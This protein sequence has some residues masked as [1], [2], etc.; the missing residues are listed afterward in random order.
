MRDDGAA[1]PTPTHGAAP[2][3][4]TLLPL[5][6]LLLLGTLWGLNFSFSKIGRLGGVHPFA[7]VTWQTLGAGTVLLLVC[8]WRRRPP[9]IRRRHLV[10]YVGMGLLGIVLPNA[11]LVNALAYVPAGLMAILVTTVPL[12]TYAGALP[13][14][15]ERFDA[16]RASGILF[17][18]AGAL[19]ILLPRASLPDPAMQGWVLVGLLTPTLYA[20]S[21]L[22][23]ARWRPLDANAISLACG[24]LYGAASVALPVTLLRGEFYLPQF[25]FT[26]VDWAICGHIAGS[27]FTFVLYFEIMRRAGAV[28]VSQVGY[29]VTF[30]GVMWGMWLFGERHSLW[31][32][33]ALLC[34]CCGLAL[35]NWR[36]AAAT[37]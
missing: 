11:N 30:S 26:A 36:R 2:V 34:M 37:R 6:M 28:F 16:L 22:Y 3:L 4:A 20:A 1:T 25:P 33:A 27:S 29:I 12:I 10:F 5:G 24:M 18:L 8:L 35:V 7:Y 32:W 14:K 17:G 19:L 9:P 21:N 23:S 15:V 31:I 13:L